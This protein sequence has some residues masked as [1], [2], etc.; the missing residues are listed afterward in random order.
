MKLDPCLSEGD[1]A[2]VGYLQA[3]SA[4]SATAYHEA[5]H[6]VAAVMSRFQVLKV[7]IKAQ[8][9]RFGRL[10][11]FRCPVPLDAAECEAFVAVA[12]LA[13]EY[14]YCTLTDVDSDSHAFQ[15]H[16]GDFRKASELLASAGKESDDAAVKVRHILALRVL[17]SPIIWP[18]VREVAIRL[19]KDRELDGQTLEPML[20]GLPLYTQADIDTVL[21]IL[22]LRHQL[23]A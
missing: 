4:Q 7:D 2:E 15:G 10:E 11:F 13:A 17:S 22:P 9:G 16:I 20:V 19:M 14:H 1:R 12:G 23:T 5:G 6:A 21:S 8:D 3:Y 18:H